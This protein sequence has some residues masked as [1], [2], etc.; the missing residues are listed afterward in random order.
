MKNA[1]H[2]IVF[3][4]GQ[5]EQALQSLLSLL[6]QSLNQSPEPSLKEMEVRSALHILILDEHMKYA[7]YLE[8]YIMRAGYRAIVLGSALDAYNHFIRGNL[9]PLVIVQGQEIISNPL[10]FQRL[11]Q[12][13]E[14]RFN[15]KPL[16]IR[17]RTEEIPPQQSLRQNRPLRLEPHNPRSE[18][19]STPVDGLSAQTGPLLPLSDASRESGPIPQPSAEIPV[20]VRPEAQQNNAEKKI[21]PSP[22]SVIKQ[23]GQKMSS[24]LGQSLGRYQVNDYLG[25][26]PQGDVYKIYDRLREND[27]ALKVIQIRDSSSFGAEHIL[28][29]TTIFQQEAELLGKIKHPYILPVLNYGRSY[30]AGVSFIYKTMP[31]CSERSLEYWLYQRGNA[32]TYHS[33]QAAY[34][35]MQIADALQHIH[36][37]NIVYQNFKLSNLLI[38]NSTKKMQGMQIALADFVYTQGKFLLTQDMK[39]LLY[40][41]PEYWSGVATTFSDQYSLAA[42]AYE[43]LTGQPPFHGTAERTL[44]FLHVSGQPKNPTDLNKE[45]PSSVN[46]VL[47]RGLAKRPEDRFPSVAVFAITLLRCWG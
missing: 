6:R 11:V 44:R 36:E 18:N 7:Q 43:L 41:S 33:Q 22:L 14:Q 30:I 31:Y 8:P 28:E 17:F 3:S 4:P 12:Q 29:D 25:S 2:D 20:Q 47:L 16:L 46:A 32:H 13:M 24:L 10:F 19:V 45:L 23:T 21:V 15:W 5:P 9:L 39:G 37:R 1:I 26:G 27:S 40:V 42:V 35:V 38:L 34:I